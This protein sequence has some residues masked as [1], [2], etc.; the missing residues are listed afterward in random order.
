MTIPRRTFLRTLAGVALSGPIVTR[1]AFPMEDGIVPPAIAADWLKRW[2]ENILGDARNRYCD[3]ELGEELGWL[4]SPFLSGFHYGWLATGDIRWLNLLFEWSDAWIKR[5]VTEPDGHLG[6]PKPEAAGTDVDTLNGYRADSLLGEAMCLRPLVLAAGA[7]R[8]DPKIR[9]THGAKADAILSL[10]ERTFE[11]WEGRAV[12]RETAHGGIWIVQPFGID[13]TDPSRF[14][15]AHERRH[16][17]KQGFSLPP[18]K[19]HEV[20]RWHLALFDV[21]RKPI[22]RE[23]A[24]NWSAEMKSRLQTRD[25]G[26]YFVWNYWQPAGPWDYKPNGAPKHWVGVHPNGG[27]YQVDAHGIIDAWE[28]GLVYTADDVRRL[29]ATNRDFMWNQKIA[30]AAFQRI[31]GGAPEKRWE[32]SPG[33]LWTALL[34]YDPTLRQIFVSSHN[35][36]GWAGLSLTPWALATKVRTTP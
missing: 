22:Y 20:A 34:P 31:D 25:N 14:T 11:K 19:A 32:K 21:T 8:A 4:V 24:E 10:A 9:V 33:L 27:Y 18:N 17:T 28:H 16:E 26:R 12:W 15:S 5:A 35:P 6:W 7:I 29:I 13:P 36:A 30:G 1:G 23:R 2:E 3:K